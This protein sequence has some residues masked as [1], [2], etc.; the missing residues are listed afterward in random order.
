MWRIIIADEQKS[1]RLGL[2][3]ALEAS[4]SGVI[5]VDVAGASDLLNNVRSPM[6]TDLV[7]VGS[8]LLPAGD[9]TYLG[10]LKRAAGVARLLLVVPHA[11]ADLFQD[12][13]SL[14]FHGLI[15]RRQRPEEMVEAIRTTLDGR[16]YAPNAILAAKPPEATPVIR[17][18]ERNVRTIGLTLRQREVLALIGK[19]LSNREIAFALNIAEAT[20]KIH[21]SAVIRMLGV[22]NR[23]EAALLA[24]TILKGKI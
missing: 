6:K 22:R 21:V 7:I 5:I 23:T 10:A 2:R 3:R 17:P 11:S 14:G 16:L 13:L 15:I 24:P 1:F 4:L 9:P 8:R 20:V 12:A 19:G 18:P